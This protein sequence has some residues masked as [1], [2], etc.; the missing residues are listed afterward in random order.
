MIANSAMIAKRFQA[1][2]AGFRHRPWASGAAQVR[3]S[4]T[5]MNFGGVSLTDF[6]GR[7]MASASVWVAMVRSSSPVSE[8]KAT[9]LS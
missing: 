2:S 7:G 8:A 1:V 5:R 3:Q 4:Q 6:F 9:V